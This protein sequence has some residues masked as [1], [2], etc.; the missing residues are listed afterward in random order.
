M[1]KHTPGPWNVE[2]DVVNNGDILIMTPEFRPL[3]SVDVREIPEDTEGIP[4]ET[5]LANAKLIAAAP[6]LLDALKKFLLLRDWVIEAGGA[7]GPLPQ[8][9]I[10]EFAKMQLEVAAF[11]EA[12][13]NEAEGRS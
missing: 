8:A 1:S 10:R 4:R 5:A 9:T 7:D 11:A 6:K 2:Q 12:A 13:V 3:A